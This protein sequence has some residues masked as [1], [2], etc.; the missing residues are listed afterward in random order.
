VAAWIAESG[1][2]EA[3]GYLYS[4]PVPWTDVPMM[5]EVR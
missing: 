4:R 1:C 3:Q 2:D 5:E